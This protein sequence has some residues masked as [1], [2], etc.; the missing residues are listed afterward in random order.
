M[1]AG[2]F[3]KIVMMSLFAM[4]IFSWAIII[5][6]Y[7]L[8]KQAQIQRALFE[9]K[10]WSGIDL[11]ILYKELSQKSDELQGLEKLFCAGVKEYMRLNKLTKTAPEAVIDGISRAMNV[12]LNRELTTMEQNLPTLATIGSISP[13]VGLFGTVWG[14]MNAFMALGAQQSA[15]LDMV[16][17]GIAEALVATALGL[18][19]AIP[20]VAAYNRFTVNVGKLE[21]AYANF[22]EELTNILHRQTYHAQGKK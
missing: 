19:A 22:I 4:S 13:Y 8:F 17:P 21:S 3:V 14:I 15:T 16:A 20:A 9:K 12:S 5:Q 1:H 7:R 11:N 6:R 10:F 18:F 2:F